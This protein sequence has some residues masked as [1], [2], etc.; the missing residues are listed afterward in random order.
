MSLLLV[1]MSL[2]LLLLILLGSVGHAAVVAVW[3]S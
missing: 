1:P 2:L 3:K